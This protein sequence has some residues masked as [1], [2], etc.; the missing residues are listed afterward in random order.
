MKRSTLLF[1]LSFTTIVLYGQPFDE[2]SE[3]VMLTDSLSFNTNPDIFVLDIFQSDLYMYYEK[4]ENP[5][6][7]KQIWM[8]RISSATSAEQLVIS[9][10]VAT[11]RNPQ[12]INFYGF[13][14]FFLLYE[15][16]I[17]GTFQLYAMNLI[18]SQDSIGEP[19][20]L[21]FGEQD[22]Y[23]SYNHP[24]Y[25]RTLCYMTGDSIM[26]CDLTGWSGN[27]T[28]T[29][30]TSFGSEN[31]SCPVCYDHFI[32][33]QKPEAGENKIWYSS[34]P[35]PQTEWSDPEPLFTE[36]NNENLEMET[37][38]P[39][40]GIGFI[41]WQ[42]S[43]TM[44]FYDYY[45]EDFYGQQ[46]SGISQYSEPHL[47]RYDLITDY[48]GMHFFTFCSGVGN[49]KEVFVA[50]PD[51]MQQTTNLSNN[52][53]PDHNPYLF[54]GR[55]FTYYYELLNVWESEVNNHIV[56]Y[57]SDIGILW[58]NIKENTAVTEQIK[59]N[60]FP[61]PFRSQTTINFR[62]N[63]IL[64]VTL[65]IHDLTGKQVFSTRLDNV[66]QGWNSF[67]FYPGKYKVRSHGTYFLE[68][69][70]GNASGAAKLLRYER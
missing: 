58:G 34:K 61:N 60:V 51:F 46:F 22:I 38:M 19:Y 59:I 40:T 25:P 9:D 11:F 26:I 27:L 30:K 63:E 68:I 7:P 21:T 28:I 45:F 42:N 10:D 18:P 41:C 23:D 56:I 17:N 69:T 20:Q 43:D 53:V 37:E 16:D 13:W 55:N 31:G 52:Q 39:G 67:I 57:K 36:G 2:W 47:F 5:Y 48:I 65:T 54:P 62:T 35:Y 24:N 66:N 14:G 29:G 12:V 4:R 44:I 70:N 3:P 1:L 6:S 50:N 8:R 32:T 33:W 49:N 64:P 15:S